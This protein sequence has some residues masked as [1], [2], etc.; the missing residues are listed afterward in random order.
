MSSCIRQRYKKLWKK[1]VPIIENN[2]RIEEKSGC[3][4]VHGSF[5]LEEP[6]ATGQNISQEKLLNMEQEEESE[7]LDE[8]NRNDN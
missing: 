5:V 6:A 3:W 1:G 8:R 2:V 4:Q 7:L